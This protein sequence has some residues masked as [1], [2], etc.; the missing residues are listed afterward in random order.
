VETESA[1]SF[2]DLYRAQHAGLFG[3]LYLIAGN[4]QEAEELMQ[5]AFLK[6]WERWD[7]IG[8]LEDPTGYLYRTALNLF[9]MRRRRAAV[10][11]RRVAGRM[12]DPDAFDAVERKDMIDQALASL[13]PRQRAAL[14]LSDL[15]EFSSD[16]AAGMLGV[17][18]V[19]VRV[20]AS[21]ARAALRRS[22][23][24]PNA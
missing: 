17:K 11:L 6:L 23:E 16:E 22:M 13:A 19:T 24:E 8:S 10:A 3:A 21:R 9:R 15:L 5:D 18:P 14:I 1:E 2:E 7:R 4:R 20:L 12:P